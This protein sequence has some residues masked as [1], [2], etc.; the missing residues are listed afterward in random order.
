M[1]RQIVE[2]IGDDGVSQTF[3]NNHE[4]PSVLAQVTVPHT[5][6]T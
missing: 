5:C 2:S 4:A 3:G 1:L 6:V